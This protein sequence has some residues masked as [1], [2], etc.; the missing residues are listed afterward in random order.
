LSGK[1]GIL[2]CDGASKGNPGHSGIGI[3][4]IIKGHK[5]TLSE[6]IG[7]ATNNIAEYKALLRGIYEAE[8]NG[9][10]IID[11]FTDSELMAKQIQGIYKVK[12]PN[13]E[14]LYKEVISLLKGFE[15][16]TI[17][18]I[19]RDLNKEADS[20]ANAALGKNQGIKGTK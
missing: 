6:Y 5:I 9:V 7:L 13:L 11:I 10:R 12:S 19:P 15:K 18:H 14:N 16:Y 1:K 20:L 4:L 2:Y 3:V 8:K 17:K